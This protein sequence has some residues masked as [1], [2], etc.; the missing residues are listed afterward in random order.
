MLQD[1]PVLVRG[2]GDLATGAVARLQR[3]GFPVLVTELPAPLAVRRTV[4]LSEAVR[5]GRWQVEDVVGVRAD[6]VAA[7]RTLWSRR[8]VPVLIDADG[9]LVGRLAAEIGV[10][11]VVDAIM[12]KQNLGT[13][14]GLAR[15]VVGVGPGF[16]AGADVHAVVETERGHNLGRVVYSGSAAPDSG[17]PG[18][19]DGFTW[20]R[21]L[22]APA[23]GRFRPRAEIGGLVTA[24]AVVGVVEDADGREH[25]VTAEIAGVVRGLL[26]DG[27]AVPAGIKVG[28]VD[29]TG[30]I[31]RCFTMSDKALAVGGGVLEAVLCLL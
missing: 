16:T 23:P 6:T 24:G 14:R 11:A 28:D 26:W 19:I 18:A 20:Q 30:E 17:A 1:Y 25:P 9:R 8:E 3:A 7:V 29:P 15:A 21:V 13:H 10:A 27:V 2:G 22:R 31:S 12:A 5:L 4:C